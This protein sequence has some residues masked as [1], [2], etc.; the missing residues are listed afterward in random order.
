LT[1]AA[2]KAPRLIRPLQA[3]WFVRQK[4][5]S[6]LNGPWCHDPGPPEDKPPRDHSQGVS[7][8]ATQHKAIRRAAV[9]DHLA[10]VQLHRA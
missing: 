8:A 1:A 9:D 10:P 2:D 4:I 3:P 7:P 6:I 5:E